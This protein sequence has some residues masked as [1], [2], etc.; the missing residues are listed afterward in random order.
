MIAWFGIA[1]IA[2]AVIA[3]LTCLVMFL[4]KREPNDYTLGATLLV[5][6]LLIAQLVVSIVAPFAGNQAVG[7]PL[8]FWM[9]LIVA[10]VL[11]FGA[12]FWALVDRRRSANLVLV[13]VNLAVAIMVYRMLVIWG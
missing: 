3:A 7:D 2:V 13:V 8:E 5:G 11:P 12:A 10:L 9:Y 1:Q 4:R 6:V